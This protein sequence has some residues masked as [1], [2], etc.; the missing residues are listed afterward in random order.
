ML[1]SRKP[2]RLSAVI[3]RN[4]GAIEVRKVPVLTVD[5]V[6]LTGVKSQGTRNQSVGAGSPLSL[7]NVGYGVHCVDLDQNR[8]GS[9]DRLNFRHFLDSQWVKSLAVEEQC[10]Q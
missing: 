1:D 6:P 4:V 7:E 8:F 9:Y 10:Q 3:T 5:I 2:P